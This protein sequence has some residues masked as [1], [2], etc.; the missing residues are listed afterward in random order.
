VT[1]VLGCVCIDSI[2]IDCISILL[3]LVE[4]V[5]PGIVSICRRRVANWEVRFKIYIYKVWKL[6]YDIRSKLAYIREM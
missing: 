4:R 6:C 5:R 2:E 1:R 3:L